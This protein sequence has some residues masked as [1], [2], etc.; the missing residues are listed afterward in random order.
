M[1]YKVIVSPTASWQ[2]EEALD[3]ILRISNAPEVVRKWVSE[4]DEKIQSLDLFPSRYPL[5]EFKRL[6][7]RGIR[8]FAVNGR[9]AYYEVDEERKTVTICAVVYGK[10]DIALLNYEYFMEKRHHVS[11]LEAK[12]GVYAHLV[13]GIKDVKLGKTTEINEA[14][15]DVL[16]GLENL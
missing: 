6:K 11:E 7:E 16:K 14:F 10:R 4:I 9:V 5:S 3:Y 13:Q 2:I 15:D 12:L 1:E 8:R